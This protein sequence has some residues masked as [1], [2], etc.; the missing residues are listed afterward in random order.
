MSKYNLARTDMK[1]G[2][3]DAVIYAFETVGFAL[4]IMAMV[5]CAGFL[6]LN[7]LSFLPLHDF[8]RFSSIAFLL[9]LVIDFLLFPNLLIRFDKRI[10]T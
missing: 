4:I 6:V 5:L 9:A 8:A 3:E 10:Y 7:T 2:P 1:L